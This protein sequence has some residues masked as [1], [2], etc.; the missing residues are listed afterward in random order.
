[1]TR[2]QVELS[3]FDGG[4]NTKVNKIDCPVWQTPDEL[5][6]MY[7]SYGAIQQRR[8]FAT[9]NSDPMYN[10][11][12]F[13]GGLYSVDGMIRFSPS[14]MSAQLIGVAAETL[15]VL[16][17][18]ATAWNM[19]ASSESVITLQGTEVEM[20]QFKDLL[21]LTNGRVDPYKFNGTEF[22]RWAIS[23]PSSVLT[24]A[25]NA[26]A[27][28]LTGDYNYVWTG[29]NSYLAEGDYGSASLTFTA[30]GESVKVGSIAT[31]PV[32]AGI[33]S[34]NIYRNTAGAAGVYYKVT[35]IA[36]GVTS[37]TDD[38]ADA[39][40]TVA[41]P[42]DQGYPRKFKY[43]NQ[44]LG[45]LWA[46]GD[47]DNP[48]Y[49]WFSKVGRPELFPSENFITV[50]AGDGLDISGIAVQNGI[51]TIS[52]SDFAGSTAIYL[53]Y[54]GDPTTASDPANW[55]LTKAPSD[56]G[57]DS[58]RGMVNFDNKTTLI[59]KQG[60]F[61]F[62][63]ASVVKTPSETTKGDLVTDAIS[64]DIEPD[65]LALSNTFLTTVSLKDM[66]GVNWKNK[67]WISGSTNSQY[68]NTI[69]VYD[70]STMAKGGNRKGGA[71]SKL[72]F[73]QSSGLTYAG[74]SRLVVFE[75]ELYAAHGNQPYVVKLDT[76]TNDGGLAINS[77]YVTAP[78]KG[79]SQHERLWKDFVNCW[80]VV[81]TAA[82]N[83]KFSYSTDLGATF[84]TAQN[85]ALTAAGSE[86]T[87]TVKV[88]LTTSGYYIQFKFAMNTADQTYT[89]RK[90][91]YEYIPRSIRN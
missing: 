3:M 60:I 64:F 10:P 30:V 4:R 61:A 63:G 45:R 32:S 9:V 1:M 69:F 28:N 83:M 54:V 77:Y 58:H 65:V 40:L 13:G 73:N 68:Y 35:N 6:V 82:Y 76:G 50:G 24:A 46:A 47:P 88:P 26:T 86:T 11:S 27:G 57:S 42:T 14:T 72:T 39:S 78:L 43:L 80:L 18:T 59:N 17:G 2:H 53:L 36:N 5:N 15:F 34:W 74:W 66:V 49:L 89:I 44:Y 20:I 22:T 29:V 19:V 21:L 7:D 52:K 84:S 33:E 62:K 51:I 90:V 55:F 41:A 85:V 37:F 31:A 12:S 81:D 71:W 25:T 16:T 38:V 79:K 23:A 87:K 75:N 91:I 67:I 70:Y 48:D 8:G 56:V